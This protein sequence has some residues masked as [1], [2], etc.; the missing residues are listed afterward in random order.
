MRK[1][2]Y[3]VS[4]LLF[5]GAVSFAGCNE[6]SVDK[7]LETNRVAWIK[8]DDVDGGLLSMKQGE[9]FAISV[10]MF[11]E[12]AV[13]KDE[14]SFQ[15]KSSNEQVATVGENGLITAVAGGESIIYVLPSHNEKLAFSFSVKV[16][17]KPNLVIDDEIKEGIVL[18]IEEES[19]EH[20]PYNIAT[21]VWA[22]PDEAAD[23][24]LTYS[25]LDE[26]IA[27]ISAAGVITPVGVGET[28][29]VV[30]WT[31][32]NI[33][34]HIPLQINLKQTYELDKTGWT[35]TDCENPDNETAF[36][37]I[38]GDLTTTFDMINTKTDILASCVIDRGNQVPFHTFVLS[39]AASSKSKVESA[40]I[41]GSDD[42]A[43]WKSVTKFSVENVNEDAK[44]AL[45]QDYTYRYLKIC[46]IKLDKSSA[47]TVQM[48]EVYLIGNK[49]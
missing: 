39:Q 45:G 33:T 47:K 28:T 7:T 36:K 27:T 11:P 29:V 35:V 3:L 42:N 43:T 30:T 15:Y 13:D 40:E 37:L 38:D 19:S 8:V 49:E 32:E 41:L 44:V 4:G 16:M 10:Q 18:E 22:V 24:T 23:K 9:T 2:N 20:T 12:E 17:A 46:V 5:I 26:T 31:A 1:I 25:I 6:D 34:L 14:Y 21:L 48:T